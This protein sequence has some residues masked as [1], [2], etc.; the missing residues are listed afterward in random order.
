MS[1]I[2]IDQLTFTVSKAGSRLGLER[3]LAEGLTQA[4]L[5]QASDLGD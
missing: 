3:Y 2:R 5:R 4:I 1:R